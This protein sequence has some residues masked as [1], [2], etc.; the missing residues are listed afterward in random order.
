M[1]KDH[2]HSIKSY[3]IAGLLVWLPIW[4]TLLVIRFI[5]ELLDN[6]LLL[7][8]MAY[9]PEQL[10]GFNVPGLGVVLSVAVVLLTGM[11]VTNF[12][13]RKLIVIWD[14]IIDRIPLVRSVYNAVKQVASTLFAKDGQSFRKVFLIEYPRKGIWSIAFQS[15]TVSEE[16][17]EHTGETM[18]TLFVP[19][20]PNPTSG[21]LMMV[22]KKEAVELQMSV[23]QALRLVISL[24]VVQP[25]VTVLPKSKEVAN[26]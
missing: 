2:K 15:G 1:K 25:P 10:F 21:F 3:I 26:G 13:G 4:I 16:I 6:S 23:D 14:A 24:G 7:L 22:P 9:R 19:T 5:V 18:L 8:P 11:L 20:T 17:Q 12:L